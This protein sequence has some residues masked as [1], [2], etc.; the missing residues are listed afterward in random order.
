M[1]VSLL[2]VEGDL[3][4]QVLRPIFG[5]NPV[6]EIGGSKYSLEP[7][8]R[9]LRTEKKTPVCYL[10][11][12]DFDSDPPTDLSQPTV[13]RRL[14]DGTVLGWRWCRHEIE[15]YLID[16]ELVAN[17]T[18]WDKTVYATALREAA[19]GIRHYQ[20]ARWVVG[21]ARRSLP[22]MKRVLTT[23]PEELGNHDFRLRR[24]LTD[25]STVQWA[26]DHLARFFEP[27]QR[28]FAPEAIEA[29]IAAR[30]ATLTEPVLTDPA[31]TLVWCSGKDLLATIEPW[32]QAEHGS[33]ARTFLNGMRD[34]VISHP[35]AALQRLPEWNGLLLAVRA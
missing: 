15:S 6:V 9:S 7:R 5:G 3:D 21:Q 16:P 32:L 28:A 26:R 4:F 34:W 29:S 12:R 24:D 23:K 19:R 13:D 14:D 27:L 17:A 2:L 35:D 30:Q 33:G 8:S 11:D 31:T 22:P 18:G 25:Q 1:L 10:R 20:I